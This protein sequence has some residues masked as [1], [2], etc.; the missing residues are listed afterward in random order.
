M[1]R[2]IPQRLSPAEAA[3]TDTSTL[4]CYCDEATNSSWCSTSTAPVSGSVSPLVPI[5]SLTK[6]R[7]E[8]ERTATPVAQSGCEPR[9]AARYGSV[10][11]TRANSA[12][13]QPWPFDRVKVAVED[14]A[15]LLL[16]LGVLLAS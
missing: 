5:R 9:C 2:R 1:P 8:R 7:R 4:E 13:N 12:P 11:R 10:T 6:S 15:A 14:L 16:E 3:G